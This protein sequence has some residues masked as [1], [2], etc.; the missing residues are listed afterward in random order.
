[1]AV[2]PA[3]VEQASVVAFFLL[4]HYFLDLSSYT[5]WIDYARNLLRGWYIATLYLTEGWLS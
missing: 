2:E 1:M 5:Q 4:N 3:D